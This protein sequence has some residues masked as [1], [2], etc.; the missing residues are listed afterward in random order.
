MLEG[1]ISLSG[2]LHQQ[3]QPLD[4]ARLPAEFLKKGG[5]QGDIERCVGCLGINGKIVT[6]VKGVETEGS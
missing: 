2:C 3:Q 1:L 6:H 4:R 5:P